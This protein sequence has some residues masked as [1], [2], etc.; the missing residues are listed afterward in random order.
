MNLTPYVNSSDLIDE[1]MIFSSV[2]T[3]YQ[4]DSFD[5][6]VIHNEDLEAFAY[7]QLSDYKK[8]FLFS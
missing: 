6:F 3:R 7:R 2:M 1:S 4:Y 8:S 5:V